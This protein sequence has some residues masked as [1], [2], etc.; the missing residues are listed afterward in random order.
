MLTMEKNPGVENPVNLGSGRKHTIK[1]VVNIIK[2]NM[3]N[4]PEII[5][6]TTKNYGDKTRTMNISRAI[7]LGF[8][9]KISLEEGIK[10]TMD[11]YKKNVELTNRRYDIFR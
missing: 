6:D 3:K 9:P 2:N 1:E 8:N 11:W 7:S 5:Y 10:N 4:K